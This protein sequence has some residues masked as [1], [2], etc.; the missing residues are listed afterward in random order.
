MQLIDLVF[1]MGAEIRKSQDL[2]SAIL[3]EIGRND[4][5]LMQLITNN[6]QEFMRMLSEPPPPGTDVAAALRNVGANLE[7]GGERGKPLITISQDKKHCM[8]KHLK[9]VKKGRDQNI[10]MRGQKT[11]LYWAVRG[12]TWKIDLPSLEMH[13][14]F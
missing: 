5:Q 1:E 7:E 9:T 10:Y 4:P 6:Q 12:I 13:L 2:T 11:N 3:Q 8:D 14:W